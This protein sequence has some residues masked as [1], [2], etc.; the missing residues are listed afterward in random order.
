MQQKLIA[1]P[2]LNAELAR[3]GLT[4]EMLADYM[5]MTKQNVYNK[6]NGR[7]LVN[8]KDMQTIQVFLKAKGGGAYTLDYL[9]SNGE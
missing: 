6:L 2:N 8:I 4:V 1:Y 3:N 7:T 5:G 9:F